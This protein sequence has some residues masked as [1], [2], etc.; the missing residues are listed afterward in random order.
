MLFDILPLRHAAIISLLLLFR[1]CRRH[2]SPLRFDYDYA[3]FFIIDMMPPHII[4]ARHRSGFRLRLF[5]C[6]FAMID[7]GY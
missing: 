2:F 3:T 6:R 5:R 4:F 1:Y 7:A